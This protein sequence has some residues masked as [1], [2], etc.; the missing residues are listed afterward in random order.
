MDAEL[1]KETLLLEMPTRP[2]V[3]NA[4][5]EGEIALPGGLRE[6]TRVL[7]A[8]A[9]AVINSAEALQD[10]TSMT[11]R[12]VFHVLYTQGDHETIRAVEASADFLHQCELPGCQGKTQLYADAQVEHVEASAMNGRLK[13]K[14]SVRLYVRGTSQTPVDALIGIQADNAERR[15]HQ[16]TSRRTTASG[17]AEV[18]LREEFDLPEGIEVT[19]TLYATA[20]PTLSD[21]S[22]GEKKAGLSGSIAI[23]AVHASAMPGKPL[24][25]TRHTL[26][27][28]QTVELA[29]ESG[30][31]L[32]GRAIVRDVAA[33][34]QDTGDGR[35]LRVEVLLGLEGWS[36][37]AETMTV[38]ADAYT[39]SGDALRLT[40]RDILCR[41]GEARG[42]AAESGKAMLL[43]PEGAKPVRTV[44]AAFATPIVTHQEPAGERLAVEGKLETRLVYMSDDGPASVTQEVP[45]RLT[46]L[47][48]GTEDGEVAL[49]VGQ[50]E[51]SAVT[52][53]RAEVR[54]VMRLDSDGLTS[55]TVHLLTDA[56]PVSAR[57][58][59][60]G[61]VLYYVQPGETLWDIA[62]RYRVLVREVEQLNP[63]LTGDPKAGQGVLIWKKGIEEA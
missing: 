44:L 58:A 38:L 12:V 47:A 52:S 55:E 5:V 50:V 27:F 2:A 16:V 20:V 56:Q 46:F 60:G 53:D 33:I 37:K 29:G 36:E 54:Y 9:M 3:T 63:E 25:V 48:P 17:S 61:I 18:L 19:D 59:E 34:S 62:R 4:T 31:Q 21:I 23:E 13:M 39:T 24:V 40:G 22:G 57:E 41:T 51:A 11:G 32:E 10:R 7:H 6:E 30:D 26:P 1:R 43:L 42:S 35:T 49:S 8:D 14:A 28:E 15:T 45:F